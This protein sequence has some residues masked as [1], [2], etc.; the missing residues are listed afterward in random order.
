[1]TPLA[2]YLEKNRVRLSDFARRAGCD[3]SQISRIKDGKQTPRLEL[4][5]RIV[6]A[7]NRKLTFR[8]LMRRRN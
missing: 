8:D 7:S 5:E 1:M 4:A 2:Q 6:K 3:I